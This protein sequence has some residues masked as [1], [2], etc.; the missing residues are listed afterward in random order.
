MA[1]RTMFYLRSH[2]RFDR[3]QFTFKALCALDEAID[4]CDE[5]PIKPTFALR[6]AL[7]Y[8]FA[9]SDG[10]RDPYDAFWR[11]VRD[12]AGAAYSESSRRY[13]RTTNARTALAGISRG[14]GIELNADIM[15]RLRDARCSTGR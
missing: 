12:G 2:M 5:A 9:V 3:D 1:Q 4:Q 11:E 13:V 7:A 8:L 14:V 6:F 15:R 10:R